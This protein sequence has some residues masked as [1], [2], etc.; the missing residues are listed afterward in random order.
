MWLDRDVT[1]VTSDLSTKR[2]SRSTVT[3]GATASAAAR[4]EAADEH[5]K[6]PEPSLLR[7]L[8]KP[9]APLDRRSDVALMRGRRPPPAA[10]LEQSLVEACGDLSW[11]HGVDPRRRQLDRQWQSIELGAEIGDGVVVRLPGHEA[12]LSLCGALDK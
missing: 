12:R 2:T 10:Q 4:V 1:T 8:E 11:R 7:G 5:A 6:V 3:S 9:I